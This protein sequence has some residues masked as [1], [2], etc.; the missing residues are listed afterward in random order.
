MSNKKCLAFVLVVML[1]VASLVAA[2]CAKPAPAPKVIELTGETGMPPT[3]VM[4][5]VAALRLA[6]EVE[7]ATEG[8]VK[9]DWSLGGAICTYGEISDAT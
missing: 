9:M 7:K 3:N 5:S 1:L 6:E 4:N 8:R 2:A